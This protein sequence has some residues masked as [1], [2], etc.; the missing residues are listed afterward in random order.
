MGRTHNQFF[1]SLK[2]EINQNLTFTYFDTSEMP[3]RRTDANLKG[4]GTALMQNDKPN[5]L[6]RRLIVRY[7]ETLE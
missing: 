3:T 4:F 6:Y 5:C 1:E 7:R 2:R